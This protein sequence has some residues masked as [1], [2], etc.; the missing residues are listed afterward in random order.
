MKKLFLLFTTG[1]LLLGLSACEELNVTFEGVVIEEVLD[2]TNLVP[3]SASLENI[4]E[5]YTFNESTTFSISDADNGDNTDE[6][7]SDYIESL[8]S[9][10]IT[11]MAFTI[12]DIPTDKTLSINSLTVSISKGRTEIYS[13][14]FSD[15]QAGSPIDAQGLNSMV[16]NEVSTA[17]FENE[18]I[19]F[20]AE[21]EI[22]GDVQTFSI[23]AKIISDIEANALDA[24]DSA[25]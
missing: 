10:T 14:S 12:L 9:V 20:S 1:V 24:I 6:N 18:E 21:G 15:I 22:T 11:S 3:K 2:I 23:L 5:T 19:T 4:V 17:L 7:L 16:L 8:S 25:L 13:E